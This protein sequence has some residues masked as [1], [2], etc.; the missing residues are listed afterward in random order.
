MGTKFVLE[1][2]YRGFRIHIAATRLDGVSSWLLEL[3]VSGREGDLKRQ[4]QECTAQN[5]PLVSAEDIARAVAESMVDEML[6]MPEA[7]TSGEP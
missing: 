1:Y 5:V 3:S 4:H 7:K 2:I 6:S